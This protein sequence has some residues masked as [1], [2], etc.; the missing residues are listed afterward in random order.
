MDIV[1]LLLGI[2][3]IWV[4]APCV[5]LILTIRALKSDRYNWIE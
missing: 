2:S 1:Y 3:L 5:T 4:F